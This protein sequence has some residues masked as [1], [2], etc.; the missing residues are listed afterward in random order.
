MR[1]RACSRKVSVALIDDFNLPL[2]ADARAL[3]KTIQLNSLYLGAPII[4]ISET[5]GRLS[6]TT[7]VDGKS[8]SLALPHHSAQSLPDIRRGTLVS[9]DLEVRKKLRRHATDE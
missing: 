9:S 7:T 5:W 4:P 1:H 2:A 8:T 3:Q 6:I